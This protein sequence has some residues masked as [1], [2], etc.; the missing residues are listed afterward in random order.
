MHQPNPLAVGTEKQLLFDDAF[1]EAKKGFT[2][3]MNPALRTEEPALT[4]KKPWERCGCSTPTVMLDGG[5]CKMWYSARGEDEVARYCYATSTDVIGNDQ[6][7][8]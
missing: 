4:P 8:D 7:S 1:V 5:I 3:T 6:L 2:I